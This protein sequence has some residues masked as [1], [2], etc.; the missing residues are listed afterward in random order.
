M[1]LQG[2]RVWGL[3]VA[4]GVGPGLTFTEVK[5]KYS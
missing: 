1:V 4:G 3:W 5:I 2:R